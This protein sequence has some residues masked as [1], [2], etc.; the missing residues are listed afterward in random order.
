[1]IPPRIVTR[2]RGYLIAI[3]I[4]LALIQALSIAAAAF[5]TRWL[6]MALHDAWR[7]GVMENHHK[8]WHL[9]PPAAL[10]VLGGSGLVIAV[11][12]VLFRRFGEILGQSYARDVRIALFDHASRMWPRDLAARR[13]GYLSL[14]F[15]G[16]LTALKDWPG[17]G[18]PLLVEG[19]VMLPAAVVILFL[20]DRGFGVIGLCLACLA[21]LALA[22]MARGLLQAHQR[23]RTRRALLAA[24]LTERLPIAPELAAL[25]RRTTEKNLIIKRS[26][27]LMEAAVRRITR[28][29]TLHA[30]PD[31]LTGIAAALLIWWGAGTEQS[32]ANIAAGLAVLGLTARPLRELMGVTDRASAFRA[33]YDKLCTALARP[34]APVRKQNAAKLSAGPVALD[35]IQACVGKAAPLTLSVVPGACGVLPP[36]ADVE[37]VFRA[38]TGLEPVVSGKIRLNHHSVECLTLGNL[39]RSVMWISDTPCILKGT[40]SR[41]LT[42]GLPKRLTDAVILS[43]LEEAGL[44]GL[45]SKLGG[46]DQRLSEGGRTLSRADR[47]TLSLLRAALGNPG[48]LLIR[49]GLRDLGETGVQWVNSHRA[50]KL[51]AS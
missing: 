3:L 43:R 32:T 18:L 40:M 50:T 33:A 24:D 11:A 48:L 41:V 6:F 10:L 39:R 29:E 14:R 5:S 1:M 13:A 25:G 45:L 21:L 31:A 38:I 16:D 47:M 42:L 35:L 51:F 23:L 15:V 17:R 27:A 34:M 49:A 36:D 22:V 20:I 8:L 2:D 46:L 37:A 12:R 7:T 30:V 28:S 19:V 44:S 9:L 4:V 26:A